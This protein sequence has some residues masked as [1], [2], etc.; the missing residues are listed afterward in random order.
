[1]SYKRLHE[2]SLN[3]GE[4]KIKKTAFKGIII[5]TTGKE[6]KFAWGWIFSNEIDGRFE[7]VRRVSLREM[8]APLRHERITGNAR[9]NDYLRCR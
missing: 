2:Q 1:M 4:W 8:L 6:V 3:Q 7:W 5:S 9:R